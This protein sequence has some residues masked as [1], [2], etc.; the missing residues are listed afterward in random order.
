[1]VTALVKASASRYVLCSTRRQRKHCRVHVDAP[2][3]GG[4]M[5]SE[6]WTD[7]KCS[8][9]RIEASVFDHCKHMCSHAAFGGCTFARWCI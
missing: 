7:S 6:A 2:T 9:N 4:G 5:D 3:R 8:G 1:M